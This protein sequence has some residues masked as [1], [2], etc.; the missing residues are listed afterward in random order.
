MLAGFALTERIRCSIMG[1]MSQLALRIPSPRQFGCR[2]FISMS[3]VV[4]V[5]QFFGVFLKA[6]TLVKQ[7]Q[8]NLAATAMGQMRNKR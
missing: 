1:V 3:F 5:G 4:L 6:I 2:W 7:F 8:D